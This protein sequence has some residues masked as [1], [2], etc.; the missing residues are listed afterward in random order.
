[1]WYALYNLVLSPLWLLLLLAR[2]FSR[3]DL[4]ERLGDVEPG[5]SRADYWVHCASVG[6]LSSIPGLL[7]EIRKR[8]P[9]SR[10][11]ISTMTAT[12][13]AR[14][15]ELFPEIHSFLVPIDSPVS[16]LRILEKVDP[17][18]LLIAET[19]LWPVLFGSAFRRGIP[20][21]I[22]NGRLTARSLRRYLLFRPLFARTLRSVVR[23]FVQTDGDRLAY[24]KL[25]VPEDR[26]RVTGTM[27]SDF[28]KPP[29]TRD[30]VRGEFS[31]PK[32]ALLVVA[33]SVRPDEERD[34]LLAF[35]RVLGGCRT[36]Y[37]VVAPRHTERARTVGILAGEMGMA[38]R[39][40]SSGSPHS[41]E[42]V[43]ILDSL[44][45]LVKLYAA[46]DA[47]FVGGSLKPYG[48]HNVLEPAMWGVPVIFGPFT[49]NCGQEAEELL[50]RDGGIRVANWQE[51]AARILVLLRDKEMRRRMGK[52][53]SQIVTDR[54]GVSR[55]VYEDLLKE[56]ILGE[57]H[58]RR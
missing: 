44:G 41:G 22:V 52:S 43:L 17:R 40:R 53:A 15:R 34:I 47:S 39:F 36:A 42:K 37:F 1:L 3:G 45:E 55:V 32:D 21:V 46:A 26:I 30:S 56:A 4:R 20:V 27:K 33:G 29:V 16:V 31:I 24:A 48:G 28:E 8:E 49:K 19:E 50:V 7:R 57:V 11:V 38:V 18:V 54:S 5:I 51:L 14:A 13:R 12:G 23:L 2:P 25:G 10:L 9:G 58:D 35:E 6:E